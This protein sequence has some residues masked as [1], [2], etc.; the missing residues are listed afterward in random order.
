MAV[1][2]TPPGYLTAEPL[3]A[4]LSEVV[5]AYEP[6]FGNTLDEVMVAVEARH[7]LDVSRVLHDEPRLA[8]DYVR[9]LSGVDRADLLEVVYHL[10]STVHQHKV[11]LKARMPKDN[12]VIPSVISVWKG[13]DWHEREA[14]EMYGITFEGHPH[15]DELLLWDGAPFA[16]QRKDTP[17]LPLE[18]FWKDMGLEER[19][20]EPEGEEEKPAAPRR[21]TAREQK[22]RL[23]A[24]QAAAGEKPIEELE[25]DPEHEEEK[26]SAPRRLTA[27][28]QKARLLAAQAAAGE[29]PT[30]EEPA[31]AT[32]R[33]AD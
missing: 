7:A 15:L 22:A 14:A 6:E 17:V 24:A 9:S 2:T 3:R 27:R 25:A 21:L 28:E 20:A 18:E 33:D 8:F 23:L 19:E 30:T 11:T 26:P 1:F 10:Y 31:E 4:L 16:P 32:P 13:A 29:K 5:A 12:P